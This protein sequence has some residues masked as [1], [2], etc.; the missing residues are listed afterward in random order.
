MKHAEEDEPC[1]EEEGGEGSR[2]AEQPKSVSRRQTTPYAHDQGIAPARSRRKGRV[3]REH[4]VKDRE[5][6]RRSIVE[7]F[8]P[9]RR[10]DG[11]DG[12]AIIRSARGAEW[13][14]IPRWRTS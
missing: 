3:L 11:P 14:G 5:R 1:R 7:N 10:S 6:P 4:A 8:V 9:Y 13:P 2:S 12:R